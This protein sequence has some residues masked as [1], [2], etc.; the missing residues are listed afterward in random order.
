MHYILMYLTYLYSKWFEPRCISYLF[1]V[2]VRVKVVFRKSLYTHMIPS[3]DDDSS[4]DSEDDCRSG[5]RNV[6]HQQQSF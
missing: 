3:S 1:G 6:S 5:S 4:L 2:I